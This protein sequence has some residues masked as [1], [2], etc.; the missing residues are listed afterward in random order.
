MWLLMS[1]AGVGSS[2][3]GGSCSQVAAMLWFAANSTEDRHRFDY[4]KNSSVEWDSGSHVRPGRS[5]MEISITRS[6]RYT[7]SVI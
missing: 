5:S 4:M 6:P 2:A 3:M 1:V 7:G